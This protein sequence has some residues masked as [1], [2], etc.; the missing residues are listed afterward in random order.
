MID[1]YLPWPNISG[2]GGGCRFSVSV[3][4]TE[5]LLQS[6]PWRA[7]GDWCPTASPATPLPEWPSCPIPVLHPPRALLVGF[8]RDKIVSV[9]APN[10]PAEN[11]YLPA[12]VEGIHHDGNRTDALETIVYTTSGHFSDNLIGRPGSKRMHNDD[13]MLEKRSDSFSVPGLLV[14][15][16]RWRGWWNLWPQTSLLQIEIGSLQEWFLLPL[17]RSWRT[18]NR[19][20]G[21]NQLSVY[22]FRASPG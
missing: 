11:H 1:V 21:A 22:L 6:C 12:A 14:R 8:G 20:H 17:S 13:V 7:R 18:Y 3:P 2:R 19:C 10:A 9:I 5:S 16:C 15:P 4:Q